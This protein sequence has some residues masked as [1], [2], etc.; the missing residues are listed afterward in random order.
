MEINKIIARQI[1]KKTFLRDG[2]LR[3]RLGKSYEV[4]LF[5]KD[6]EQLKEIRLS[7][8]ALGIKVSNTFTKHG[9]IVQ[10]IYGKEITYQFLKLKPSTALERDPYLK[11]DKLE[12]PKKPEP[13][14]RTKYNQKELPKEI[15]KQA[16]KSDQLKFIERTVCFHLKISPTLIKSNLRSQEVVLARH[17]IMYFARLDT[18]FSLTFIGIYLGNR[19]HTTILHGSNKIV[20]LMK[21]DMEINKL[22]KTLSVKL[23]SE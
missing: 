8:S 3:I 18:P 9:R 5:P 14:P 20:S 19:N 23:K 1:L 4:R 22:V 11:S 17:L 13:Q 21:K 2:Y 16:M 10:P 15:Y 7:I 6:N 12:M